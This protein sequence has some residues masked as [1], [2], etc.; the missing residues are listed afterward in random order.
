[1]ENYVAVITTFNRKEKLKTAIECLKNQI[2]KPKRI[3][4]ID[5]A[6]TDGTNKLMND[7]TDDKMLVYCK[8]PQNLG[9]AGGFYYGI[10]EAQKYAP[11]YIAISD[12]DAWYHEDYFYNIKINSDKREDIKAFIGVAEDPMSKK[13]VQQGGVI[14]NKVTLDEISEVGS[15]NLCNS[16]TFCGFVFKSELIKKVGLP[17]KDFFIWLD[18]RE[19]G[20]RISKVSKILVVQDAILTHPIEKRSKEDLV[21]S[22]KNYYGFRNGI[23]LRKEFTLNKLG[24]NIYNIIQLFRHTIAIFVKS[25]YRHQRKEYLFSYWTAFFNAYMGK[26]GKNDNF[27]P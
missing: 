27:L 18:D 10:K 8:L 20:L 21:S 19:Y 13:K 12:D 11:D 9:G 15:D 16:I 2:F 14:T 17:R 5:N 7:Y 23:I 4:V 25:K 26:L 3:I 6:S 1:M 24:A 22:W